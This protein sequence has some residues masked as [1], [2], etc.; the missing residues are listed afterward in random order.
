MT[1]PKKRAAKE[2]WVAW[3]TWLERFAA[4]GAPNPKRKVM[5]GRVDPG[6]RPVRVARPS[7][8]ASKDAWIR[9]AEWR[10]QFAPIA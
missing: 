8:D 3:A 10:E 9:Y 4:N 6:D 7:E 5:E 2:I 1:R